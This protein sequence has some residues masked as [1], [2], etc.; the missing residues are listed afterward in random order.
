MFHRVMSIKF[1]KCLHCKFGT[2]WGWAMYKKWG[3]WI[4]RLKNH[5]TQIQILQCIQNT[6][7]TF[8]HCLEQENC[9]KIFRNISSNIYGLTLP[10]RPISKI[11]L[12]YCFFNQWES[13]N[14]LGLILRYQKMQ[15]SAIFVNNWHCSVKQWHTL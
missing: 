11:N 2:T 5:F 15:I 12:C 8:C 4:W 3:F 9:N 13:L 7:I 14:F 1:H 10:K 6:C